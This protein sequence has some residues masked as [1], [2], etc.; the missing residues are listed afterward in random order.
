QSLLCARKE[1]GGQSHFVQ[2]DLRRLP[3]AKN[4]FDAI[5]ICFVLEHLPDPLDVLN[6]M[7]TLLKPKGTI[8]AIEGD[9]GSAFFHPET[10]EALAVW[11]C[12][13]QLQVQSN[14]DGHIGRRLYTIFQKSEATTISIKP[15]PVYCDPG[16]PRMME[17]FVDKTIV[18]ML[19]GIEEEVISRNMIKEEV[20]H[21]GL[22]SLLRLSKS[23]EG[24]FM[25]TFFRAEASY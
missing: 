3:F 23:K 9:H 19:R 5:F 22:D 17:G 15:L 2:A 12:L 6:S 4:T 13:Q 25:Y 10:P 18:G 16:L 7:K 21:K 8:T 20:W 24:T 11:K 1:V 14:G